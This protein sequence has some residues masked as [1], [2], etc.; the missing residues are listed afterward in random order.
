[1]KKQQKTLALWILIIAA[2]AFFMNRLDQRPVAAKSIKYSEF[3]N[4]VEG[5]NVAEVTF[6]GNSKIQGKFIEG[7]EDG[8]FFELVGNTGDETFKILRDKGI[9][10][11]YKAEEKQGF[12]QTLFINWFPMILL[13]VIFFFFLSFLLLLFFLLAL[14][15]CC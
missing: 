12:F 7:Y 14:C 2:M 3:I 13:F 15:F 6:Q 1:M 4:A 11:N 9:T 8:K 10:P 5:G